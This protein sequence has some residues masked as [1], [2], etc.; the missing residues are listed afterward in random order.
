MVEADRTPVGG[1]SVRRDGVSW[2]ELVAAL[3]EARSAHDRYEFVRRYE[4]LPMPDYPMWAVP[5][6]SPIRWFTGPDVIIR[7]D[8]REWV[9]VRARTAEALQAVREALLGDWLMDC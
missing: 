3:R 2:M 7:D 5:E 6:G 1:S 8:A 4:R 9:W